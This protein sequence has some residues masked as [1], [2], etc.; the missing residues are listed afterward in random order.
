MDQRDVIAQT[1]M[2]QAVPVAPIAPE[3]F[4]PG[5]EGDYTP[6]ENSIDTFVRDSALSKGQRFKVPHPEG[7]KTYE[8]LGPNSGG[9]KDWRMVPVPR[10]S[11][12]VS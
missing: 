12:L 11:D 7:H 10:S 6:L 4:A 2:Q 9:R 5:P 3:L 1:L 8:Y